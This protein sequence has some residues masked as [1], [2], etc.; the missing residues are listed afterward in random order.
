[1]LGA[2]GPVSHLLQD[3]PDAWGPKFAGQSGAATATRTGPNEIR[4]VAPADIALVM[5][6]PQ[7]NRETALNSDRKSRFFAPAGAIEIVPAGSELY[8]RWSAPKENLLVAIAPERLRRLAELELERSDP[9]L[10]PA[11]AG[12]VDQRAHLLAGMIREELQDPTGPDHL[13]LESL[14]T[15]LSVH[16]LR[17]YSAARVGPC[18]AVRGGLRPEV[19]SRVDEH[20]R[21]GL[22][23]KLCVEDLAQVAGLSPSQF[24]RAFRETAGQPPHQ[25]IVS[26]RLAHA[27]RLLAATELP[28]S[29]VAMESGFASQSHLS[30]AMR[31]YWAV[32]PNMVRQD[33]NSLRQ[34]SCRS[35]R[36]S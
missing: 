28:L 29:A 25:Y 22:A 4:L 34:N 31:R 35:R 18:R 5:F 15:V 30:S 26:L 32:T 12:R 9:A 8:A 14:I 33:K 3:V 10:R 36:G 24:A 27:E 7:P 11:T 17:T 19:W 16:V 2:D 20:I 6:T 13:Y 1:M 21:A 23:D